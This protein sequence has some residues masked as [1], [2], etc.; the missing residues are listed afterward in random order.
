MSLAVSEAIYDYEYMLLGV[1]ID[2]GNEHQLSSEHGR[3]SRFVLW[4]Y[5]AY[6]ES[7][8]SLRRQ[9]NL[10]DGQWGSVRA[11]FEE[12][13]V[14]EPVL[15]LLD[16]AA[17][18]YLEATLAILSGDGVSGDDENASDDDDAARDLNTV[19]DIADGGDAQDGVEP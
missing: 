6:R 2:T 16:S 5:G 11:T 1:G 19:A 3:A 10:A 18:V 14:S 8:F 9:L 17:K 12:H 15:A 13:L 7:V 4:A